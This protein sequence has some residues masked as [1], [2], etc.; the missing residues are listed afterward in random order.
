[1]DNYGQYTAVLICYSLLLTA[2]LCSGMAFHGLQSLLRKSALAWSLPGLWYLFW[3]LE[4]LFLQP[5]W[6]QLFLTFFSLLLCLSS[7]FCPFWSTFSQRHHQFCWWAQ[8]CPAV[9]PLEPCCAWA[10]LGLFSQGSP[11]LLTS[12]RGHPIQQEAEGGSTRLPVSASPDCQHLLWAFWY[13]PDWALIS[14]IC[15]L[16]GTGNTGRAWGFTI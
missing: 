2:S 8:P 16:W 5:C 15:H 14:E 9:G 13:L 6:N 7:I 12:C 10:D 4:H 11:L 3:H 1:M